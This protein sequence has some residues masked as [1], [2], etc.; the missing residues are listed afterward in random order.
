MHKE[1]NFEH[2]IAQ[3]LLR[4]GGYSKR[5]PLAFDKKLTIVPDEVVAFVQDTRPADKKNDVFQGSMARHDQL[6]ATPG[7]KHP[8][9]GA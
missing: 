9:A 4:H 8:L 2:S 7:T 1:S 5:I 3:S 6:C